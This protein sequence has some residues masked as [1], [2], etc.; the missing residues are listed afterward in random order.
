LLVERAQAL[1]KRGLKALVGVGVEHVRIEALGLGAVA[2]MED[3]GARADFDQGLPAAAGAQG[4]EGA[5]GG[6]PEEARRHD[7]ELNGNFTVGKGSAAYFCVHALINPAM[8]RL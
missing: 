8:M 3:A 5:E 7:G 2:D 6:E 1:E 4:K